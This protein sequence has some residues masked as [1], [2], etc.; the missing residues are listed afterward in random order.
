METNYQVQRTPDGLIEHLCRQ[1]ELVA[2][3]K[4]SLEEAK[5]QASLVK[6]ANNTLRYKLDLEKFKVKLNDISISNKL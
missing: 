3:Q 2:E 6:Q 1:M 4:I 5:Q